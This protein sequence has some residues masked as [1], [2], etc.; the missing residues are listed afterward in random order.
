FQYDDIRH[1]AAREMVSGGGTG[2]AGADDYVFTGIHN[3]NLRKIPV[4]L[5]IAD[6]NAF[7]HTG[8]AASLISGARK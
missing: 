8:G 1:A 7:G 4:D 6:S 3:F 5:F 2:E